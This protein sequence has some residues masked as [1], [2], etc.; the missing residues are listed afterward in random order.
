[1]NYHSSALGQKSLKEL[2]HLARV[3]HSTVLQVSR[4][5]LLEIRGAGDQ[6]NAV[7]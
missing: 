5:L 2:S 6:E 4:Q 3:A 7:S 1:M